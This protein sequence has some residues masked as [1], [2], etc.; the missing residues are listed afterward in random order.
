MILLTWYMPNGISVKTPG[1]IYIYIQF[2]LCTIYI[3]STMYVYIY[4]LH[5]VYLLYNICI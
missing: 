3:Y 4:F 5:T 2:F 1:D